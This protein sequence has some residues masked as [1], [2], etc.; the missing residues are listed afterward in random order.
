MKNSYDLSD[1]W[2][3]EKGGKGGLMVGNIV[4]YETKELTDFEKEELDRLG[5]TIESF[6]ARGI[7]ELSC[8]GARRVFFAPYRDLSQKAESEGELTLRFSLPS[9]SYATVLMDQ[10]ID[11]SQAPIVKDKYDE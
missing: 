10:L 9:G 7:N 11:R 4:G 8:K 5:L 2:K 6:R 1:A 3:Y